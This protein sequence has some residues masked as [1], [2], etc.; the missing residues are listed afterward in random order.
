MHHVVK[1]SL[2][3]KFLFEEIVKL[4]NDHDIKTFVETGTHV[5]ASSII[6]SE[7]FDRVITC[8]NHDWYFSKAQENIKNS[9]RNNI[10]LYKK[11][12]VELFE[13]IVP[14]GE[15]CII[16]LDA[17]ADHDFPLLS[18]L[19]RISKDE[20]KHII[21]IHD[22]YVPDGNGKAKFQFDR[23]NGNIIN[24]EYVK[25]SLDKIYGEN[26]Y[27]YYFLDNQEISG[28]IYITSK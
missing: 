14:I 13:E 19:D 10:S 11:S 25:D 15:K 26:G 18:E 3:D 12:S 20:T 1:P 27:N 23:W 5:A 17:H 16:F 22:F 28:V 8:E 2:S 9:N 4:K 7:I 24:L 6:A 21:I